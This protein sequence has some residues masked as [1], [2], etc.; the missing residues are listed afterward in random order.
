MVKN[1]FKYVSLSCGNPTPYSKILDISGKKGSQK[2]RI[3]K[4]GEIYSV[5]LYQRGMCDFRGQGINVEVNKTSAGG[6]RHKIPLGILIFIVIHN[7]ITFDILK[8]NKYLIKY[9]KKLF[10]STVHSF[11]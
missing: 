7:V 10:Q 11:P 1:M 6:G 9:P 8:I 4:T 5:G 3:I 2:E